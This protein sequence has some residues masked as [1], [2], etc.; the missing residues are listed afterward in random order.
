MGFQ[1]VFTNKCNGNRFV[2]GIY[3]TVRLDRQCLFVIPDE[4]DS[5]HCEVQLAHYDHKSYCWHAVGRHSEYWTD[6]DIVV[7]KEK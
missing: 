6:I 7:V 2:S 3:R 4:Q 5:S 1:V